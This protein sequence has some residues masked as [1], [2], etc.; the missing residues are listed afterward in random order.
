MPWL[1]RADGLR[2][3]E[4]TRSLP[5]P[6]LKLPHRSCG[7]PVA[8][9]CA[10]CFPIRRIAALVHAYGGAAR[11][12]ALAAGRTWAVLLVLKDPSMPAVPPEQRPTLREAID[13]ADRTWQSNTEVAS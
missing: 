12:R 6:P 11:F 10:T 7:T 1:S 2:P 5:E 4:P 9:S 13:V 3:S 8:P